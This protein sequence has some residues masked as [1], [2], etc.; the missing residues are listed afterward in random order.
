MFLTSKFSPG[1]RLTQQRYLLAKMAHS[2]CG[3]HFAVWQ[4]RLL[5]CFESARSRPFHGDILGLS[6]VGCAFG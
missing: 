4:R 3:W 6:A 5:T 1:F 2:A